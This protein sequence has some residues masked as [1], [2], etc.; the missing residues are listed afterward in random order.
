MLIFYLIC[1]WFASKHTAPSF[2][3]LKSFFCYFCSPFLS[4]FLF[5]AFNLVLGWLV[6]WSFFVLFL[7]CI[8][9]RELVKCSFFVFFFLINFYS[10]FIVIALRRHRRWPRSLCCRYFIFFICGQF[11]FCFTVI[12]KK[13]PTSFKSD[14]DKTKKSAFSLSQYLG[15]LIL[16]IFKKKKFSFSKFIHL[17]SKIF[18]REDSFKLSRYRCLTFSMVKTKFGEN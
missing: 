16:V 2:S 14:L 11:C 8:C 4:F 18:T 5:F 9:V 12:F 3:T 6:G 10:Y 1:F 13:V 17:I 15:Y 7:F